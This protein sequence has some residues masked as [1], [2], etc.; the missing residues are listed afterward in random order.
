M[1]RSRWNLLTGLFWHGEGVTRRAVNGQCETYRGSNCVCG[2]RGFAERLDPH[3]IRGSLGRCRCPNPSN[4]L[5]AGRVSSWSLIPASH[6][7][8]SPLIARSIAIPLRFWRNASQGKS[9]PWKRRELEQ[10]KVGRIVCGRSQKGRTAPAQ[11]GITR[12]LLPCDAKHYGGGSVDT[13]LSLYQH[14]STL[15]HAPLLWSPP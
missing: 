4:A 12:L 11:A 3:L 15:S 13:R 2:L 6:R 9:S 1:L 14:A 10:K 7:N 8:V 5:S